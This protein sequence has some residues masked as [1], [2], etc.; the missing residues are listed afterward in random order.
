MKE[1]EQLGT[2]KVANTTENSEGS[3]PPAKKPHVS[4]DEFDDDEMMVEMRRAMG[5]MRLLHT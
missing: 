2:S 3:E 5:R 1:V 4:Y